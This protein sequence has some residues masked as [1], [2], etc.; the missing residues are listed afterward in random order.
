[1]SRK[2]SNSL[3]LTLVVTFSLLS[4]ALVTQK[5]RCRA[6][7][8]GFK[9]LKTAKTRQIQKRATFWVF[10]TYVFEIALV[11]LVGVRTY[12][13][14]LRPTQNPTLAGMDPLSVAFTAFDLLRGLFML[15][16]QVVMFRLL[17]FSVSL[18]LD[19]PTSFFYFIEEV[20]HRCRVASNVI[21]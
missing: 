20:D 12:E 4:E 17:L 21:L 1:M 13:N 18:N 6:H 19:L 2:G 10:K 3:F 9:P 16:R 11:S 15:F 7:S 5:K 8:A 14:S